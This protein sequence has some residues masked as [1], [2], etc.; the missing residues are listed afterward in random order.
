MRAWV[1][2]AFATG[3]SAGAGPRP[4]PANS[5][6]GSDSAGMPSSSA[7]NGAATPAAAG[8]GGSQA[9]GGGATGSSEGLPGVT[10][11]SSVNGDAGLSSPAVC[12]QLLRTVGCPP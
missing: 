12:Q 2:L 5:E 10:I 11:D 1:L 8:M 3:C 6:A 9:S 7:G 4:T